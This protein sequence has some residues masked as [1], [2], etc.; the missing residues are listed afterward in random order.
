MS[1]CISSFSDWV[2]FCSFLVSFGV[3]AWQYFTQKE[4]E[5]Q[6]KILDKQQELL[7]EYGI[8]KFKQ[9]EED[10]KKAELEVTY[11]KEQGKRDCLIIKNIGKS[12]ARNIIVDLEGLSIKEILSY[13]KD[14]IPY[15]LLNKNEEYRVYLVV[16]KRVKPLPVFSIVWDDDF[17]K[18]NQ[19]EFTLAF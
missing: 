10:N 4:L 19:K 15:V 17:K 7:N 8:K 9:I 2:A 6:R 11:Y 14:N 1:F 12:S 16:F 3:A 18:G 13:R 5:H